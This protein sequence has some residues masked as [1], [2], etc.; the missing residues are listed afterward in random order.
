MIRKMSRLIQARVLIFSLT[1]FFA[2]CLILLMTSC[3][4]RGS[5]DWAIEAVHEYKNTAQMSGFSQTNRMELIESALGTKDG[6]D[7]IASAYQR[8]D[9]D[10]FKERLLYVCWHLTFHTTP[11][12]RGQMAVFLQ[13][14]LNKE[15][16]AELRNWAATDLA[17][18]GL[19]NL[20]GVYLELLKSDEPAMRLHGAWGLWRIKSQP[21]VTMLIDQIDVRRTNSNFAI[22]VRQMVSQDSNRW[23][24]AVLQDLNGM[25]GHK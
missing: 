25:K 16:N 7:A 20:S 21:A 5:I 10:A 14:I 22:V 8:T 15:K 6:I 19:P 1:L 2:L 17:Y 4:R 11:I 12:K 3:G 13:R 18:C 23:T 9:D 24:A